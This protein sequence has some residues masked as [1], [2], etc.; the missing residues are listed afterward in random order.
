[1]LGRYREGMRISA[2]FAVA[3][4]A[5]GVSF[6]VLA[7][8]AD[9]GATAA[10]V[11]SATTW[12]GSA[13]FAVAA[14]LGSGGAVVSAITAGVLLNSRYLAMSAAVAPSLV[15][16]RLRRA[17]H[18]LAIV[19]E[20]WALSARGDGTFDRDKL[21]GVA[22]TL[23]PAW[24]L[25]TAI[26]ALS[27]DAIGDPEA[28]GLDAAFPAL[29]FALMVSQLRTRQHVSA[30]VLGGAIA[31]ILIPLTPAGLPIIAASAAAL[32]GLRAR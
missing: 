18:G 24:V 13:Q 20:S 12:A 16:S 4:V 26:G 29:F 10:I 6:G 31:L 23:Y 32:I 21:V 19:D 1:M 22:L 30:A 15:G 27:G 17:L 11:F 9:M 14:I 28:L 3:V 8:A 5:F 2:P 7:R 25:G